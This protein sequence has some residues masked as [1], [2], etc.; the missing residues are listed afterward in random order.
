[1]PN[2]PAQTVAQLENQIRRVYAAQRFELLWLGARSLATMRYP[3]PLPIPRKGWSLE[4]SPGGAWHLALFLGQRRWQL[5]LRGGPQLRRQTEVLSQIAEGVVEAGSLVVRQVSANAGD[6]R[7]QALPATRLMVTIP[8]WIRRVATVVGKGSLYARPTPDLFLLALA[9]NGCEWRLHGGHIR[10]VLARSERLHRAIMDDLKE[11]VRASANH[12]NALFNRLGAI[13][14]RRSGRV[15]AWLHE[16]SSQLADFAARCRVETVVY[17]DRDRTGWPSLPWSRFKTLIRQ[18][19]DA[20]GISLVE[21][22]EEPPPLVFGS[23]E[24][25]GLPPGPSA[26]QTR[27]A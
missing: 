27:Y 25:A 9:D 8:V 18:K 3:T 23:R 26:S 11:E 19:L 20:R 2:L 4:R 12:R 5:R 15:S 14:D 1:L 24:S 16:A 21:A 6:H 10:R 13:A 7:S 22:S 17:D